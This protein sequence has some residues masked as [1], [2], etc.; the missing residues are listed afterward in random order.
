[1]IPHFSVRAVEGG[2]IVNWVEEGAQREDV[3]REMVLTAF[4]E[5][6]KLVEDLLRRMRGNVILTKEV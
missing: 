5:L 4:E 3:H 6:E 2:F 1:M